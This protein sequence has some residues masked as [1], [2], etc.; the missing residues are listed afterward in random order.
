MEAL[1]TKPELTPGRIAS[2]SNTRSMQLF[3]LAVLFVALAVGS[4]ATIAPLA[5]ILAVLAAVVGVTLAYRPR[6]IIPTTLVLACIALPANLP[7]S[8]GFSGF[9]FPAYE[10]TLVLSFVVA[11]GVG[12]NNYVKRNVALLI[13]WVAL[14]CGTAFM[15]AASILDIIGDVRNPLQMIMA[16]AIAATFINTP[17][18]AQCAT[19]TK[20]VLWASA[21]ITLSA[22]A[23]GTVLAGRSEVASLGGADAEATR[24]LTAATFPALA[25]L[26][27]CISMALIGSVSIRSTLAWTVPA[28]LI[29]LM[30]FSRNHI[31]GI[32]VTIL[33]S[34]VALRSAHV[35]IQAGVRTAYTLI[36]LALLV[37]AVASPLFEDIP[38]MR[39]VDAQVDSYSSR[40]IE[41]VSS[42]A[43]RSDPSALYRERENDEL[44]SSI[45]QNPIAG[46]G[47][48]YAYQQP[49]GE[50]GSWTYEKAPF[51]AHNFYLWALVKTGIL[52]LAIF[53]LGIVTQ[54]V[55][56][57]VR[58]FNPT[59]TAMSASALGFLAICFVAPMPLGSPTAAILGAMSG[60]VC[61]L[62]AENRARMRSHENAIGVGENSNV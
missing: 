14:G 16:F 34:L 45:G 53:L 1:M 41:G 57:I 17:I 27:I 8:F 48:G 9:T 32:A 51:Y 13:V 47:F 59:A 46:H 61:G 43:L 55:R 3:W 10:V 29:L 58:P 28:V 30:S 2:L 39:W 40:V 18:A 49:T 56:A 15:M 42:D 37:M 38:G 50:R 54:L 36:G 52:G 12:I 31:L 21:I 44:M 7:L 20:W 35:V 4:L 26:C 6:L 25:T 11:L 60:A 22:S 19:V 33:V 62:W 23:T 5:L 24:Y